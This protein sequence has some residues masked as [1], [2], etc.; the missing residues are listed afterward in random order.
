MDVDSS[1]DVGLQTKLPIRLK[2]MASDSLSCLQGIYHDAEFCSKNYD[3]CVKGM[4]ACGAS[5]RI[6]LECLFEE[7]DDTCYIAHL[8]TND[9][10]FAGMQNTYPFAQSYAQC[11][12][13]ERRGL[14]MICKWETRLG[15]PK[16]L[17]HNHHL[18]CK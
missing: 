11:Q 17:S 16:C 15:T 2:S 3:N 7:E 4:E 5:R 13:D 14:A 10:T 9:N 12:N 18:L 6:A 8:V 1:S